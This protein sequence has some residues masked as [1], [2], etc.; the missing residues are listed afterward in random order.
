MDRYKV[1]QKD[2]NDPVSWFIIDLKNVG[3][4]EG[5]VRERLTRQQAYA[6]KRTLEEQIREQE[7]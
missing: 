2:K 6:V 1:A 5:C 7:N 4:S 3:E